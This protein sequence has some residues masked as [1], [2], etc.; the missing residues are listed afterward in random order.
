MIIIY[1]IKEAIKKH[2]ILKFIEFPNKLYKDNKFYIP[3]LKIDELNHLIKKRNPISEYCDFKIFLCL[4]DKEKIVGRVLAII[5]HKFNSE[6]NVKQIRFTRIDMIDDIEVTKMLIE[7]VSQYGK[8]E[9]MNEIIGPI[10]FTDLDKE[11]MLVEGF[12][13]PNMYITFYNH[14][15]YVEHLNKLG[16]VKAVDWIEYCVYPKKITP[17]FRDKL[18]R[19]SDLISQRFGYK[20]FKPHNKK[21][22]RSYGLDMFKMY[23]RA[24]APLY[25]F[26]AISD[27]VMEFYIKQV[28]NI[29]NR[30][31]C[32]MVLNKDNH[33]IG[34]ALMVPSMGEVSRKYQGR[35]NL[36]NFGAY[37]KALSS[38]NPILD[39]YF[40][41]VEPSLMK[42]GVPALIFKD[43]L[44]TAIKN[45]IEIMYTG[46]ELENNY[47]VINF[48]KNV[49]YTRQHR[50]RRCFTKNI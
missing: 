17:E 13:E 5:N 8:A 29:I 40:I 41:A 4:N 23:N 6:K 20:L 27:K 43:A 10:G 2:D 19:S 30:D 48:W 1:H 26:L 3:P 36:F 32:W 39:M 46:P 9:G 24:F 35:L 33:V 49:N 25:G 12:D 47:N 44:D 7:A 16:F 11:G 28:V 14:P 21:E 22:I 37:L 42:L 31:Y 38:K 45:K 34:F 18:A 15:Y 50:R